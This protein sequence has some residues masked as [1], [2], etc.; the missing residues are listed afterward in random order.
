[1]S[2]RVRNAE[3]P[4]PHAVC[5]SATSKSH[6]GQ[7]PTRPCH[8]EA[9]SHSYATG[10]SHNTQMPRGFSCIT[11]V[12]RHHA[13]HLSYSRQIQPKPYRIRAASRHHATGQSHS[14]QIPQGF[15]RNTPLSGHHV[16]GQLQ[17]WQIVTKTTEETQGPTAMRLVSHT[18]NR[19][20]KELTAS[21][22]YL[23]TTQ[24]TSH[25]T[26]RYH[27]DRAA[28]DQHTCRNATGQSH[29]RQIADNTIEEPR[30]PPT[31]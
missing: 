23:A 31:Q 3:N 15:H 8:T 4:C 11:L 13:T 20:S 27:R 30:Q 19:Y 26:D 16:T 25:T 2:C 12:S 1:M 18:T 6:G 24:H 17:G 10:Q 21:R 7:I 22:R 14:T 5:P 29:R 9:V 28:P